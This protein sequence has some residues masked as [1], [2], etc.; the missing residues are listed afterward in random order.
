MKKD[1]GSLI[2]YIVVL[3]IFLSFLGFAVLPIERF[4]PPLLLL[5]VS[6]I[7]IATGIYHGKKSSAE[8]FYARYLPVYVPLF[9]T[10]LLA[11]VGMIGS[12]GFFGHDIWT[13]FVFALFPFLPN[14]FISAMMGEFLLV[15]AVPFAYY[16]FFLVGFFIAE[17][18]KSTKVAISK[19]R[20]GGSIAILL[21]FFAISGA[22][23]MERAKFVLPPS[24]GFEYGNGFSSVD[25]E[26]YTVSNP[27]NKLPK[28]KEPASFMV[29][30]Q[31]EMPVLDGAEAAFPVYSAFANATYKNISYQSTL[32]TGEEI[33]S[34]TN[35]I[36]AFERLLSG[37][38][39]IFFGAQPS[40]AQQSLAESKGKELVLTPI[41]KEAFVFF[42]NE[43]NPI[44]GLSSEMIRSIYSGRITHWSEIGGMDE[45]ILAFQRPADSGSQTIM[46][47]FMGE[48]PLM[49]ALKEEVAGMGDLM[50]EVASYRNYNHSL[51]YS[52][53]F[54][55]TGMNPN[56]NIK[57][58]SLDGI[59][60]SKENIA[61]GTY[62]YVVNLYAITL[63]DNPKKTIQ[64]MLEWMQGPQGQYLVEEVGYI[65]FGE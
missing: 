22:I 40:A 6:I 45:K 47:K 60:P 1:A 64:P 51:G 12:K 2:V 21:V 41:G 27:N 36:Y 34:F 17:R 19:F 61:N 44:N 11:T 25:L 15:F 31:D 53:R 48:A 59:E 8:T 38:V 65:S 49:P 63:K 16:L 3:P 58:L 57:L 55:A 26:P 24:Y 33:V 39:D 23:Y 20:M 14:S 5:I 50:E 54:F 37:E 4:G 35:T 18:R 29:E 52:F 56:E 13:F 10:V 7:A 30:N 43:K 62:P 32:P 28:L 46:E 42:V 9:T